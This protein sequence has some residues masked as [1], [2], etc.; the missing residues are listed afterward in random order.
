MKPRM[1]QVPVMTCHNCPHADHSG[2]FTPGGAKYLCRNRETEGKDWP[3]KDARIRNKLADDYP[4]FARIRP[5]DGIIPD[6]CPLPD[7]QLHQ[8]GVNS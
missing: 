3:D 6:W 7:L 1:Y 4:Y 2:A 8:K 5:A